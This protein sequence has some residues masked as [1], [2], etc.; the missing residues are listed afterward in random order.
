MHEKFIQS[1]LL[2]L[3]ST[4]VID[5]KVHTLLTTVYTER[6]KNILKNTFIKREIHYRI[7]PLVRKEKLLGWEIYIL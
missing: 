7:V 6:D 3:K 2:N 5:G 4:K 1:A